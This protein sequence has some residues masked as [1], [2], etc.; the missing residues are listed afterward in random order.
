MT[1][2]DNDPFH[3][4]RRWEAPPPKPRLSNWTGFRSIARP[5]HGLAE[6]WPVPIRRTSPILDGLINPLLRPRHSIGVLSLSGV[7]A[8]GV[9]GCR[10]VGCRVETTGG[11]SNRVEAGDKAEMTA[12]FRIRPFR[13]TQACGKRRPVRAGL[14]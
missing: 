6:D 12:W 7:G 4:L 5:Q 2:V 1:G 11:A 14:R 10:V 13:V 3:L 9:L 8:G